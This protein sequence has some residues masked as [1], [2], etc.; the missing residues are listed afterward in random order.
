MHLVLLLLLLLA[1][2]T[3]VFA[4]ALSFAFPSS[5]DL[6][7]DMFQ[8]KHRFGPGPVV[9][10]HLFEMRRAIGSRLRPGADSAHQP[11]RVERR[12]QLLLATL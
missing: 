12:S 11:T 5:A 3:A 1:S 2:S 8:V 4:Q 7:R 10:S 9:R 6:P